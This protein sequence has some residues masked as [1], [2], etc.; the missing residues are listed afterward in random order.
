MS[1]D[2]QYACQSI[3]RQ[4]G[5]TYLTP[6]RAHPYVAEPSVQDHR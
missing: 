5:H 4:Y 1:S 2:H 3:T 6:A